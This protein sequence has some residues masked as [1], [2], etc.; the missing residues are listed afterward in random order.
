VACGVWVTTWVTVCGDGALAYI[1]ELEFNS[2]VGKPIAHVSVLYNT[3]STDVI[4]RHGDDTAFRYVK[5][6]YGALR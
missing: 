1:L 4:C 5:L 3:V 6:R 2:E